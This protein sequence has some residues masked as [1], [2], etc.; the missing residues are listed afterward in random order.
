MVSFLY[1]LFYLGT[2]VAVLVLFVI[3]LCRYL[4]AKKRNKAE[5]GRVSDADLK[6]RRIMLIVTAALL[7]VL[8]AIVIALAVLLSMAVAYM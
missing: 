7:G 1:D 4:S 5:P 2:P 6:K 8:V 3:S